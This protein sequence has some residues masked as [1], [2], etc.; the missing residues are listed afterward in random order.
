LQNKESVMRKSAPGFKLNPLCLALLAS[1]LALG[2]AALAAPEGG[3]VAAGS[4]SISQQGNSTLIRQASD[5]AI[6]NW[7]GFSIAADE[8]VRFQQP[9]TTSATLNRVTGAQT[10]QLMGS[11]DANGQVFLINPN[12]IL[13]GAGA[14]LN[15]GSLIASTSNL[16]DRDFLDGRLQFTQPG[17]SGTGIVNAGQITAAEGGLV[18]LVAPHVRNDGV[19][20]ARLGRV[21]IGAADTFTLDLYGDG[22]INLSLGEQHRGQLQSPDGRPVDALISHSGQTLTD[23]GKTVLITAANAATVLDATI[24]MAGTIRADRVASVG[25]QIVLSGAGGVD[26]SGRIAANG[27]TGGRIDVLGGDVHLAGSARLDASGTNGGGIVHVG[28]DWQGQGEALHATTTTV[29]AGAGVDVRAV[30]AGDGGEA[31][32]WSD[33]HTA[34]A[35]SIDARGGDAAGKGG[36]VEVS[37][38]QTLDFAGLV[39]A[40]AV[41]G[42]GGSLLL[43]PATMDI[44]LAEA[45]LINRVLRL[46]VSTTVAADVD[47][48]VNSLIDGRGRYQG[49]GLSLIAGNNINLNDYVITNNGALSLTAGTGTLNV[50]AG[51]AAFAGS[52]PISVTTGGNLWLTSLYTTGALTAR[53]TGGQLTVAQ[54]IDA[55]TGSVALRAAQDL[56]VNQPLVNF[57]NGS[58][59]TL[60]SDSGDIVI[61]AQIDGRA[62]NG[63]PSGPLSVAAG[64]HILLNES[65]VSENSA[66]ALTTQTG[67][68]TPAGGKGLF[69]GSGAISVA[70]GGSLTSGIYNTTGSLALRSTGGNL[71][72][73]EKIY[74][75]VG[76]VSL[77]AAGDVNLNQGVANIRNGSSLQVVADSGNINVNARIDAQDAASGLPLVAGGAV[78]LSAGNN[79]NINETIVTNNGPATVTAVNGSVIFSNAGTDGSGNK[80]IMTGSAPITVTSGGN[81]STGTAPPAGMVF[82]MGTV[83]D[84]LLAPPDDDQVNAFIAES[85]KPWVTLATTGKLTLISTG[86]NVTIDAPIPKT[87]GELDI[88][89]GNN[90]V[91]NDKLVNASTAPIGITAGTACSPTTCPNTSTNGTITVN[92]ANS[93]VNI[94][95]Q[96]VNAGVT[97]TADRHDSAEVD[98]RLGNL[99]MTAY[100]DVVINEQ[101]ATAKTLRITS[102]AGAI[103]VGTIGNSREFADSRPDAVFLSAL[104]D[105]GTVAVPFFFGK[106][107]AIDARATN[108]SVYASVAAPDSLFASA[109]LDVVTVGH[110]GQNPTLHAGRDIDVTDSAQAGNLAM[111]A[112]RDILV[113][114]MAATRIG[115]NAGR[116]VIFDYT[117]NPAE[118]SLW[119]TGGVG[120][121]ALAVAATGNISFLNDTGISILGIDNN[122]PS[123]AVAQPSL[124]L[125]AGGNIEMR[126]LQT[127]GAV[128]ISAGGNINLLNYIGPTI[129]SPLYFT[130]DQGVASLALTA[131]GNLSM[132]GARA[133]GDIA[134]SAGSFSAT[135]AIVSTGGTRTIT[136][137]GAP[138]AY[139]GVGV[140]SMAEMIYVEPI[141][142]AIP[143]GPAVNAPAPPAALDALATGAPGGLTVAS[144]TA[145]GT[146]GELEEI[147]L[148]QEST[149]AGAA[150]TTDGSSAGSAAAPDEPEAIT[151]AISSV[152]EGIDF[153]R[154]GSF[155]PPLLADETDDE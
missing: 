122:A 40:S 140:D 112:G 30:A 35:G 19:I 48:N 45:A 86:G 39:D 130:V 79:V 17:R 147:P 101:V 41:N 5:R 70:T 60:T 59:L 89:A 90:V 23:G 78:T 105:I 13:I 100:G 132:I 12:G 103:P 27:D 152:A 95:I 87:T 10:S 131:T 8:A 47:I 31:V 64:R 154:S 144:A 92:N 85:L 81:F 28:G 38:K 124:S 2:Q 93:D 126:R 57:S 133:T 83:G 1:G 62:A 71:T 22:L 91:V 55:L 44:G 25:G 111:T 115:A 69:A 15:V 77:R 134:I 155:A 61:N 68:V 102:T 97:E 36:R 18:A 6:I 118:P 72:L 29:D 138:L 117:G 127:Y 150:G 99:T 21:M 108:G 63:V 94:T 109:G 14:R 4:A 106:A 20:Q 54:G 9:S 88:R 76:N 149:L 74:E 11:L 50:A 80:K 153:G 116:D 3:A 16:E 51:K 121:S 113:E 26:V 96:Y 46:G 32:I 53:S 66:I 129:T 84:T 114:R 148:V 119:L 137:A 136:V 104:Q 65:I 125:S 24:N 145:P 49:G 37:G 146:S 135:K 143:P 7:R 107:D 52:A 120:G 151:L 75:T 128:D 42:L 67:T 82:N 56:T 139:A 43:D 141:S 73:G 98:A 33:G 110:L 142:P 123:I 58:A 34:F